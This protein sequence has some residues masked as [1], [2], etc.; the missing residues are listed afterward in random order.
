MKN[1]RVVYYDSFSIA[2]INANG[3]IRRLYCP[4]L[5]KCIH[6]VDEI[7]FDSCV[8]VD[9][10]FKDPDDKLTYLIGGNLYA[11]FNFKI[12]INF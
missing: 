6:S 10:V 9:Q 7:Q 1:N 8:Y 2:V 4:F 12:S 3:K 5:V 11:Y